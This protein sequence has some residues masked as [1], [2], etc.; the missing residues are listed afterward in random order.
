MMM[1]AVRWSPCPGSTLKSGSRDS[2]T[3]MRNVPEPQRQF[4]IRSRVAGGTS[5]GSSNRSYSSFG[6]TL[7]TTA[8]ARITSPPVVTTPVARPPST[9]TRSTPAQVRITAPASIA[10]RAIAWVMAPMPPMAWPQAPLTPLLCP[11]T[12]CS[13]T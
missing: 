2:A 10:E 12:W 7:A 4:A 11:N 6:F 8:R 3:F 1:P 13:S 5:A 9:S